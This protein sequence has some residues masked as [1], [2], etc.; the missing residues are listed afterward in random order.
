MSK[1]KTHKGL[2]DK[3]RLFINEFL[4]DMNATQA[5]IRAGY[6]RKSAG[7]QAFKLLKN[8]YIQKHLCVELE[9]RMD[10][11]GATAE[12]VIERL[13]WLAFS[14]IRDVL[15]WTGSQAT[16]KPSHELTD[17]EASSI[18]KVTIVE[19]TMTHTTTTVIEQH[20]QAKPLQ[21]LAR[22]HNLLQPKDQAPEESHVHIHLPD[23][24][25][26]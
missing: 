9:K 18:K 13:T 4:I 16:L 15:S 11:V 22:Y 7:I 1:S 23:N 6:S 26:G 19:N 2:T 10:R 3:Q 21:T 14:D 24:G 20:D 8:A 5:A 12:E 17:R 25:R